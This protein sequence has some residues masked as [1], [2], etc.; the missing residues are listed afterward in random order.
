M[1][2]FFNRV[3]TKIGGAIGKVQRTE[4]DSKIRDG[5]QHYTQSKEQTHKIVEDVKGT[6]PNVGGMTKTEKLSQ[7]L[8]LIS[9][10]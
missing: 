9:E 5:I 6:L 3:G 1:S 7:V 8:L 4:Y 2:K 10:L